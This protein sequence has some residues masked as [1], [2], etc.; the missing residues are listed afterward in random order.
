MKCIKCQ[1]NL[2]VSILYPLCRGH[3]NEY[4]YG[5]VSKILNRYIDRKSKILL[6][7]SGG[8]DS[9][10]LFFILK[11]L[12]YNFTPVYLEFDISK[13]NVIFIE[14]LK[15]KYKMDIIILY[16]RDYGISVKKTIERKSL[17]NPCTICST[18]RRYILNDYA[19]KNNYDVIATGHNM[20]DILN[21]AL[22]NI[23]NNFW[24]GF[25]NTTPYLPHK[26]EEKIVSRIKPFYLITDRE[27]KLFNK[28]NKIPYFK[29]KC[30]YFKGFLFKKH[31]EK[32]EKENYQ[33]LENMSNSLMN[34]STM[35]EVLKKNLNIPQRTCTI[36]DYPT[37]DT[38][39]S[40]CKLFRVN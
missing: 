9:T 32:I 22:N 6:A 7:L 23:K 20:S 10:A 25:K 28:I 14:K 12:N 39:C 40:F 8:K 4:I 27:I 24:L 16:D 18:A 13:D 1:K 17:S 31:I 19:I 34:F 2:I 30:R 5:K 37:T 29:G 21:Q 15:K 36:C 38:I 33:V 26:K 3:F 11:K 35:M